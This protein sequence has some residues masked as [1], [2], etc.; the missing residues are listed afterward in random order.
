MKKVLL[1]LLA[2]TLT[3]CGSPRSSSIESTGDNK[4]ETSSVIDS[5][6]DEN[7]EKEEFVSIDKLYLT[8]NEEYYLSK[9]VNQFVDYSTLNVSSTDTSIV[10]VE[11]V[12]IKG[13]DYGDS[14]I[15]IIKDNKLQEIDIHVVDYNDGEIGCYFDSIDLGRL[16]NKNIVFF[17]DSIT[18]NWAKYPGG[19]KDT[20]NDTTSLGYNHIPMLNDVCNFA[21]IT[22]AAWS[23]GTMS[24]IPREEIPL[25]KTFA[26]CAENN[27]EAIYNQNYL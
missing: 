10:S 24:T 7:Y 23:G 4:Q 8:I 22:N 20:V 15:R 26:Y 3:S 5:T 6:T 12:I 9:M 2:L 27:K 11:N 14:S 16:Y 25:Y 18:H 21:S 13:K 1:C 19:N 17:G